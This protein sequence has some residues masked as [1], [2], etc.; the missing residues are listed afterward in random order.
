MEGWRKVNLF[1]V[2]R[3][4]HI[5][6]CKPDSQGQKAPWH[7]R[8][9]WHF[10]LLSEEESS[11]EKN[12]NLERKQHSIPL[13]EVKA[14]QPNTSLPPHSETGVAK[15]TWMSIRTSQQA[16]RE[17]GKSCRVC[18]CN[19]S[20]LSGCVCVCSELAYCVFLWPRV[21]VC[22]ACKPSICVFWFCGLCTCALVCSPAQTCLL[23]N[24]LLFA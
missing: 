2:L 12:G 4:W 24:R 3:P 5:L 13:G 15:A 23:H 10:E 22:A 9:Y 7:V 18:N 19:I 6:K 8:T 21:L 11:R 17:E 14:S 20:A 16:G 1:V